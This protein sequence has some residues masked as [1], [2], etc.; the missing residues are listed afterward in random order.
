MAVF[1][2]AL[3]HGQPD[4]V[5]AVRLSDPSNY[6]VRII[7]AY[8]SFLACMKLVSCEIASAWCRWLKTMN[9][10]WVWCARIVFQPRQSHRFWHAQRSNFRTVHVWV[11]RSERVR[12][13]DCTATPSFLVF[14]WWGGNWQQDGPFLW[15]Y[16]ALL[17]TF[18]DSAQAPW[19]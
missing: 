13:M 7:G 17:A 3:R 1:K 12:T 4:S 19:A 5:T 9:D 16:S 2:P 6:I 18:T 15:R 10:L 11:W 8:R 14:H